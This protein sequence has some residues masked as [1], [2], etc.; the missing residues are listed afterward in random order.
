[1]ARGLGNHRDPS[2]R[3]GGSIS[4]LRFVLLGLLALASLTLAAPTP[5]ANEAPG[6]YLELCKETQGGLT[7]SFDFTFAGRTSSTRS[8]ARTCLRMYPDAPAMTAATSA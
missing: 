5:S 1:M 3:R 4:R 6:G 8:R 7:G 2:W